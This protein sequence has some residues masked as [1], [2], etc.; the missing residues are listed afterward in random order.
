MRQPLEA[1]SP[2]EAPLAQRQGDFAPS[3][4]LSSALDLSEAGTMTTV[5]TFL[6]ARLHNF[7]AACNAMGPDEAASFVN[8]VRRMLT[9]GVQKLG[10]EIAQ[11]RPDSILAV[12]SNKPDDKK[13]NHAQRGLHAAILAV[14][15]AVQLAQLLAA[16]PEFANL[17]PLTLAVGVHLGQA[18]LSRRGNAGK[19]HAVGDA[20]EVARLLE[21]TA[22]DMNWSIAASSGTRLAS[23]GRADGGRIG[24]VGLP[25]NSFIDVVEITGLVPRKGSSTP[26][27]VFEMLRE[28]LAANQQAR[29]RASS[30]PAPNA[31][32]QSGNFLIEGYRVLRKIG[33]GGMAS[34]FLAQSA[35]GGAP[36]VLKVMRLDKAVEADGLQRFIQE[37]ALL[38]QIQHPNVARIHRQDFSVAHAYIAMEY[39]PQGDLRAR[40]K[41]GP[42]DAATA[43][44]YIKQTAAGLAAIHAVGIVHRDLKPD[45]LMLRQDGTLALADFGVAKQVSMKIT[46]TGDG[47]IVGTPYYLSPEQALGLQ[48][49]A[50][51]DIYS[52]GVLAF[53][54]LTGRKP[55]QASS[56]QELLNLHVH[57]AV[58]MLP[59]QHA[60]L[61]A[62]MESMMAKDREQ[63][64][65]SAQTL[66]ADL[67]QMGL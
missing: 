33:E 5:A 52:L 2:A 28:S 60:H 54:L 24:S 30:A 12:F 19:V 16:R 44:A 7:S 49:D 43:I 34:I 4:Q 63:R 67:E 45:N 3:M 66:L 58:P 27:R 23:A 15:E 25:D 11:R 9:E 36:Q 53:E 31:A 65:P 48:V 18:E 57:G 1:R 61:Q 47:D 10:G 13:P 22:M 35:E 56:A 20:V 26:M 38:A 42:I 64:Y 39:F 55:Y 62:V 59:P 37:Y 14:H 8:E 21:V 29:R 41:A 46:D 17:P 51:C 50:R 6:Y 40:M 32:P